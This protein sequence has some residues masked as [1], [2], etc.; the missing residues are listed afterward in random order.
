MKRSLP[1]LTFLLSIGVSTPAAEADK[2]ALIKAAQALAEQ[3]SYAWKTVV[4]VPETARFRQ[5]PTAGKL[6]KG[7]AMFVSTSGFRGNAD[8]II[9]GTKA[10]T[11]DRE[12]NWQSA[13]AASGGQGGNRFGA[14]NPRDFKAPADEAL[15]LIN[16]LTTLRK[17][18]DAYVSELSEEDAKKLA[19]GGAG[20]RGGGG[21]GGRGGGGS[22]VLFAKGSVKFW[23][24]G[25]VLTKY[26][27]VL[28]ASM[29][30]NGSEFVVERTTTTTIS[31]IGK[32][33]VKI[34]EAARAKLE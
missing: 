2:D 12:G 19:A 31:D 28:D 18:G 11:T 29:D 5:G 7:V 10:A 6:E 14:P 25:G 22:N 17:E 27:Q 16:G 3:P 9:A 15:E 8:M 34:P 26:Q 4:E 20:R 21:G 30:F 13:A 1:L 33:E 32:T 24:E 23:V